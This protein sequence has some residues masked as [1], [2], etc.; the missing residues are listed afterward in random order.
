MK[1]VIAIIVASVLF[2]MNAFALS[3]TVNSVRQDSD[4]DTHV[5]VGAY[6]KPL[7]GTVDA[8]KSMT[9]IALTAQT[10]GNSVTCA[11]GTYGGLNGWVLF[12]MDTAAP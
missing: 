5:K 8:V 1:T 3:G 4:G 7:V 9:A 11:A 12:Q 6:S 2:S 10:S